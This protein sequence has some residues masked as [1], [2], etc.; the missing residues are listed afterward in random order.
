MQYFEEDNGLT[1]EIHETYPQNVDFKNGL[2]MCE[3]SIG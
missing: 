1:K 2:A 3:A